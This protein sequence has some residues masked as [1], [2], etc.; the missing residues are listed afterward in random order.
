MHGCLL[1]EVWEEEAPKSDL[2]GC[3][4]D[5]GDEGDEDLLVRSTGLNTALGRDN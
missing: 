5:E 4:V 2:E 3:S 1:C